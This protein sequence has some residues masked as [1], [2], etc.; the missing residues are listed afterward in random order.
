MFNFGWEIIIILVLITIVLKETGTSPQSPLDNAEISHGAN[1]LDKFRTVALQFGNKPAISIKKDNKWISITYKEYYRYCRR[2]AGALQNLGL[3]KGD[4]V[5]LIG[6]NS[7]QWFVTHI[8]SMMAGCIPVSI[9]PTSSRDMCEHVV[10]S[11]QPVH[12]F[13]EDKN[14]LAKF[15]DILYSKKSSIKS[16]SMID[17]LPQEEEL[18]ALLFRWDHLVNKTQS[19]TPIKIADSTIATIVYSSGSTDKPKAVVL[20]HK[21]INSVQNMLFERLGNHKYGD[22][23][24]LEL[25]KEKIISY[26]P[27][28]HIASQSIDIYLS[29]C[30][31][32]NVYIANNTVL[33]SKKALCSLLRE[34]RPT[35]F[36]GVPRVWEKIVE[37]INLKEKNIDT[38]TMICDDIIGCISRIPNL[39]I[40]KSI[41][42]DETK[43]CITLGAPTSAQIHNTMKEIELPLYEVYGLSETAGPI[44]VSTP[45]ENKHGSVGRPLSN[46]QVY[47]DKKNELEGTIWIKG[48]SVTPGYFMDAPSTKKVIN[49]DGWFN[50]GDYGY[51]DDD[52]Y[53]FVTGREKD[54]II[55]SGGENISPTPI[56]NKLKE[57]IPIISEAI[58]VGD[59]K[60]YITVLL[61]PKLEISPD[62]EPTIIFTKDVQKILKN[63]GSMTTTIIEAEDDPIVHKIIKD[64]IVN[65]NKIAIT[66]VH[67][68]KRWSILP[69]PLTDNDT[70]PTQKI[71]RDFVIKKFSGLVASMYEKEKVKI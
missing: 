21:N 51:V 35:I 31:A 9:Y 26:L 46:T 59:N 10:T 63:M 8:G 25:A 49:K 44:A 60:K 45:T 68:I 62:G 12:L 40:K 70:T 61:A 6:Y 65:T 17:K 67:E 18:E 13:V 19:F 15:L 54:I 56:E 36:A 5:C 47:I 29:V 23:L 52:G 33:Q 66:R 57:E 32:A 3:K 2:F 11:C 43:Y 22:P 53:L 27:V 42:L 64:G 14:Q 41:G 48:N 58:L 24:V 69:T 20:T 39:F 50:T 37:S 7:F 1:F 38:T 4:Y 16:V 34:V 71:K 55:T 30:I 28:S